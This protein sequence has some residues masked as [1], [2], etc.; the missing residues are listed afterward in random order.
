MH[1]FFLFVAF[2][3]LTAAP[4]LARDCTPLETAPGVT[5]LPKGCRAPVQARGQAVAAPPRDS[6]H[7][8]FGNTE[9]RVGGRVSVEA[10]T[11]RSR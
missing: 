3:G 11:G 9:V 5:S 4:S 2:A 1:R 6:H 8:R 10:G 7:V